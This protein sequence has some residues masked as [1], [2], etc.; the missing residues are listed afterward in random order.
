VLPAQKLMKLSV[1][2]AERAWPTSAAPISLEPS[3]NEPLW[4]AF[5]F[6][7]RL[8]SPEPEVAVAR[9]ARWICLL[10]WTRAW[11][12]FALP[13]EARAARAI[14]V[15]SILLIYDLLGCFD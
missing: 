1:E 3:K 9:S 13:T 4:I 10:A 5:A 11:T 2:V 15:N 6:K 14:V 12:E 8:L 7:V